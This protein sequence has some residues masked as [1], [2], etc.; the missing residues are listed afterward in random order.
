MLTLCISAYPSIIQWN[1][2]GLF[3]LGS[4]L[5]ICL[6]ILGCLM[7]FVFLSSGLGDFAVITMRVFVFVLAGWG[8]GNGAP[9]I[10]KLIEGKNLLTAYLW[11]CFWQFQ[12][13]E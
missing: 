3:E 8:G 5:Y 4:S 12:K 6:C 1:L 9:I 10:M 13:D 2:E 7:G 11:K